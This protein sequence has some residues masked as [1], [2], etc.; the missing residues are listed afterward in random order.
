MSAALPSVGRRAAQPRVRRVGVEQEGGGHDAGQP[1]PTDD[2]QARVG[3][4]PTKARQ[5]HPTGLPPGDP[6]APTA[7]GGEPGGGSSGRPGAD[8]QQAAQAQLP[9][10]GRQAV[11]GPRGRPV[12]EPDRA[13][14]RDDRHEGQDHA[15]AEARLAQ[16]RGH[17]QQ[18][19]PDQ[20]ELLLDAQR[21]VV[22]ERRGADALGEVVHG[23][24]REAHVGGAEGGRHRVARHARQ[25][26]RRHDHPGEREGDQDDDRGRRQDAPGPSGVEGGE[27]DAPGALA[28]AQQQAGDQ[29]AGE[30]EEDVH[31]DVAAGD[32]GHARMERQDQEDGQPAQPLKVRSEGLAARP[33]S[34]PCTPVAPFVS[35]VPPRPA[36]FGN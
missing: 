35:A 6:E 9:G 13:R 31:P 12:G 11:E 1:R 10:A 14:E 3:D 36:R 5:P 7:L 15:R 4:R 8:R 25:V 32:P 19:R 16:A 17:D 29:E 24:G 23:G 21:P 22:Q 26:Q 30:D 20:V 28:L 18:G 33:C 34:A 2:D 27:V